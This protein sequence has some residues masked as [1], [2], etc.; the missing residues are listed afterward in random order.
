[1]RRRTGA[2][3]IFLLLAAAN[4]SPA[5]EWFVATNGSDAA[6][7]TN[8]AT[9][10]QTIQAGVDAAS[11]GDMVWVSNGVYATGG[12]VANGSTWTNRVAVTTAITLRSVNGPEVTIIDGSNQVR[13]VYLS[14]NAVLD[15]ITVTR[16]NADNGGGVYCANIGILT[17]CLLLTNAAQRNGG[18]VNG[19]TLYNCRLTGNAAGGIGYGGGACE[20]TLYNCRLTGNTAGRSDD[21]GGGGSFGGTLNNCELIG[22]GAS[23][24]GGAFFGRL[25]NCTLTSNSAHCGGGTYRVHQL[26]NSIIYG[27][28][29]DYGPN[30]FWNYTIANCWETDP[31]FV[32]AAAGNYRL[33][34]NSPC[35]DAGNNDYVQSTT[36]LDG[37][38]RIINGMA[39]IGAYEVI[40]TLAFASPDIHLPCNSTNGLGIPILSSVPW[41]ASTNAPWLAISSGASGTTNG[42]VVF[43]VEA[44]P[45]VWGARTGAMV[46]AGGG[47]SCT[48]LVV[49]AGTSPKLVIA[50]A[51]TNLS[52]E[53]A[54]EVSIEVEANIPWAAT[55]NVPWLAIT[56]GETG[57][58]NGMV[59]FS[60]AASG[61]TTTRT[62]AVVVAGGGVSRTCSVVQVARVL[63]IAPASATLPG[64]GGSGMAIAVAA[65]LPWMA[66]T[67]VPWIS[68]MSGESGTTNGTLVFNVEFNP[69]AS[70]TGAIVFAGGGLVR[71]CTVVQ[72]PMLAVIPEDI[73]LSS[74]SANGNEL[75]VTA[76]V[77]WTATTNVSWLAITSGGSGT[78]NGTVVFNV[79]ANG[80]EVSR[81]GAIAIVCSG[82]ARTCLVSQ[83]GGGVDVT[84]W[85]VATN[86]DDSAD[87]TS[88]ATAKATIQAGVVT[89]SGG[90]TIW[91]SN[92]VYI[93][94]LTLNKGVRVQSSNGPDV[95]TIQG[96]NSRCAEV[97]HAD[98][99]ISGFTLTGGTA[100]WGG[101]AYISEG[102]LEG[103]IIR[104]NMATGRTES[105]GFGHWGV[106][107]YGGGIYGGILR[108]CEIYRNTAQALGGMLAPAVAQGG[109]A[110]RSHLIN[111]LVKS[112]AVIAMY[113]TSASAGAQG[114]GTQGGTNENCTVVGNSASAS[115]VPRDFANASGGGCNGST[116]LNSIVYYNEGGDVEGGSS[117]YS[118]SLDIGT[119]NGNRTS[120]PSFIN[121]SDGNYR[122]MTN[123]PCR[124]TGTNRPWMSAATDLDGNPRIAYGTVDMGAYERPPD[125]MLLLD[126][127]PASTNVGSGGAI[128]LAIGVTANVPWTAS[129][130]VPWLAITA[131]ESGTTNGTVV[132]DVAANEGAS[133]RAGT[134]AVTGGGSS[135]SYTV[136]QFYEGQSTNGYSDWA[137]GITNGQTNATDCAAGDGVPNLLKYATGCL[138]PMEPDDLASLGV[139]GGGAPA[140]TFNRN[141]NAVDLMLEIQGADSISNGA[142]WRGVATNVG[143]SWLG[144]TNVEES[145][146]G[147]PV[148]CT[149]TDPL[150]LRTNRF[151]RLKVTRP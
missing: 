137:T 119:S 39:D 150:A 52:F 77:P 92:G 105:D 83:A 64:E 53:E 28:F 63:S 93:G 133:L 21:G 29:S 34:S 71:T 13:G 69:G 91:V 111:C 31:L 140:L 102:T 48:C 3:G 79:A 115:A 20:S 65:N 16:G 141:L 136:L 94:L 2:I 125:P 95:T 107:S 47:L 22:N 109:G 147:N 74:G 130:N 24:G 106:S 86:G 146:T 87:G 114:G 81:T 49:Q 54:S 43:G 135:C 145:G 97:G 72:T 124:D 1:M 25:N 128:G 4:V 33:Q 30:T 90:D 68:I 148:E 113:C 76:N 36:D 37:N 82:I 55:T 45:V 139:L 138:A 66:T 5:A 132:F 6:A 99:T 14:T 123:S 89:S 56:S 70:R 27:N 17:N 103:C 51:A 85:F 144:A 18:G 78:T 62:G 61:G 121:P 131:G 15:G 46:V 110:Y 44:N 42:T 73:H 80:G 151:L 9:A 142:A 40:P 10:K 101:G 143:G 38:P 88:W 67:N 112:N 104:D 50:P 19:G 116:I 26:Y 96:A 57:T 120:A 129:T 75:A 58:T 84:A 149:V 23:H 134:I 7:G 12:R 60:V 117:S 11:A 35:I 8:W 127:H 126:A 98:A 118:C 108:N 100:E 41:T 122:L 59:V 32:N